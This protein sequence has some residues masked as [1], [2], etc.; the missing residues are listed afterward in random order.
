MKRENEK[1]ENE[2][3]ENEKRERKN[4]GKNERETKSTV[5][6]DDEM[7]CGSGKKKEYGNI[8]RYRNSEKRISKNEV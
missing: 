2:K 7:H 3:R 4:E 1:R 6:R 5:S 8:D